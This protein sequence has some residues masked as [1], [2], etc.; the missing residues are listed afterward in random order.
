MSGHPGT[1]NA[2]FLIV[3]KVHRRVQGLRGT[4]ERV[5]VVK[6]GRTLAGAT[7]YQSIKVARFNE[8]QGDGWTFYAPSIRDAFLKL[9]GAA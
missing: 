5:A 7:A 9:R 2:L 8:T 4:Q 3:V 6:V 1:S